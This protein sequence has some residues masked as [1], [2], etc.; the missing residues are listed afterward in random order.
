MGRASG[1]G[2]S[3]VSRD[4]TENPTFSSLSSG[5][6]SVGS[7]LAPGSYTLALETQ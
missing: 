2:G 4:D 6:P 1:M 5:L 7:K 3:R